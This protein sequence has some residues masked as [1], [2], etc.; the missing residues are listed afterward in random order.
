[1]LTHWK[2][3]AVA[4]SALFLGTGAATAAGGHGGGGG[5]HGGGGHA[6]GGHV[7]SAH[8]GSAHVG[9]AHYAPAH[10][11]NYNRGY[12]G[13]GG[14]YGGI[15]YGGI[16]YLGLGYGLGTTYGGGGYYG[17]STGYSNGGYYPMT[18]PGASAYPSLF[19]Q[20]LTP[21]SV[22]PGTSPAPAPATPQG[23]ATID[24]IA[25]SGSQVWFDGQASDQKTALRE[26]KTKALSA[27]ESY[28]VSVKTTQ[29]GSTW[30]MPVLVKAGETVKVDLTAM[31]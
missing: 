2:G 4:T 21:P 12:Y 22:A 11:G 9:G 14:Y 20:P 26:Y 6:G 24:V 18:S 3:L 15:G 7:G 1:M 17:G 29:S 25:P 8:V 16:G 19:A 27:G 31:R 10:S 23:P 5:G 30:T 28:T 13:G